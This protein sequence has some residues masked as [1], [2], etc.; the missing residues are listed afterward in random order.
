MGVEPM[1]FS[2]LMRCS[3]T[4]LKRR[5]LIGV[6]LYVSFKPDA[7]INQV[8]QG[9]LHKIENTDQGGNKSITFDSQSM[10]NNNWYFFAKTHF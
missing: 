10:R 9:K 8:R 1:T 6:V 3:T 2:L 4:K 7:Q 5:T